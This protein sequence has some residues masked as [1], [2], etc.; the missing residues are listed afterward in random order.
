MVEAE[1]EI[2]HEVIEEKIASPTEIKTT[3]EKKK[4]K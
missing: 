2:W 1:E 4:S 3:P